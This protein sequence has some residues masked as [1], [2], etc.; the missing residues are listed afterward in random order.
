MDDT[1]YIGSKYIETLLYHFVVW[2]R[3]LQIANYIHTIDAI[4]VLPPSKDV[5]WNKLLAWSRVPQ[6]NKQDFAEEESR[7]P[8]LSM[9]W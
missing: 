2:K 1:C 6:D 4:M 3:S 9:V 5:F 7:L 8:A